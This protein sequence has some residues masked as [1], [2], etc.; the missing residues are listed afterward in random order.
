MDD[1]EG[2]YNKYFIEKA[3]GSPIDQAARYFVLRYDNDRHARVA[4]DAYASSI[5]DEDP[6]L[7]ADILE[8]LEEY[9]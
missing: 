4:L 2:L 8:A 1:I 9:E 7:A 6:A 3:D 5:R